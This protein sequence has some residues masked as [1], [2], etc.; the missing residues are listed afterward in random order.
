MAKFTF[1]SDS[2]VNINGS[3]DV[4]GSVAAFR[5]ALTAWEAETSAARASTH[6]AIGA[7]LDKYGADGRLRKSDVVRAVIAHVG[8]DLSTWAELEALVDE[9]LSDR[10]RYD[11]A[12]GR[13]GGVR[14][15]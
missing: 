7:V 3:L 2:L 14:R 13:N 12:R 6:A 1:G 4:E 15:A 9:C 10:S 8:A 5:A 11:V